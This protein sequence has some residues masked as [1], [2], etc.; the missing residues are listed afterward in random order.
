MTTY[1]DIKSLYK[2]YAYPFFEG[3]YNVNVF[4]IRNESLEVDEFNDVIGV[5]YQDQRGN[6]QCLTFEGTTKPG[7]YYLKNKLGN[8]N[9]TFILQPG[10]YK[11]CWVLGHHKGRYEALVQSDRAEFIGWRDNDSDGEFDYTG[12]LYD[13]VTGLNLHTTSFKSEI[14]KVGPYSAGC[15]VCKDDME[16]KILLSVIKKS[17]ELYGD[18]ISFSLFQQS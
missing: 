8:I 15:I 14:E 4:G 17:I 2:R 3:P 9:G 18:Y 13:D 11:Q 7:L 10:H 6:L 16:F 5:A 1:Y 12:N